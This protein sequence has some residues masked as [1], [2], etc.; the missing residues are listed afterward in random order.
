MGI[1]NVNIDKIYGR[2]SQAEVDALKGEIE[3]ANRMLYDGSG[4][5]GDF[6]AGFPCRAGIGSEELEAVEAC[7]RSLASLADVIVV[8]GSGD[9][10]SG[11]K[12]CTKR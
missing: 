9:R 3:A 6:L 5:G 7:A 12:P 4:K 10:T 11:R 8:I 2:A 1:I